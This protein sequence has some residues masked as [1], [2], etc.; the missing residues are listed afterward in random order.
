MQALKVFCDAA[1][2]LLVFLL[3]DL[4]QTCVCEAVIPTAE[5]ACCSG[6]FQ[7]CPVVKHSAPNT[8]RRCA[9]LEKHKQPGGQQ[10]DHNDGV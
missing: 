6:T 9:G 5:A 1:V 4:G 2:S 10:D 3:S 7:S 8:W